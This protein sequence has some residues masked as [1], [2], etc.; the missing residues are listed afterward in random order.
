MRKGGKGKKKG[1]KGDKGDKGAKGKKGG[2]LL[3][4][5]FATFEDK[6]KR[7]LTR[8]LNN[9][10]QLIYFLQLSEYVAFVASPARTSAAS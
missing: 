2:G 9:M 5:C 8:P 4:E 6:K 1:G 3:R 10:L 7:T